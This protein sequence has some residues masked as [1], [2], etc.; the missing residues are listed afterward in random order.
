MG[1]KCLL[2]AGCFQHV[3]ENKADAGQSVG[4]DPQ[5][6]QPRGGHLGEGC[7]TQINEQHQKCD[8]DIAG[9][10]HQQVFY[11]LFLFFKKCN[12]DVARIS[13][14]QLLLQGRFAR[15]AAVPADHG[16]MGNRLRLSRRKSD[17]LFRIVGM[18][19][20]VIDDINFVV[21][22]FPCA[23]FIRHRHGVSLVS[24]SIERSV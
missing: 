20:A 15:H 18:H 9:I 10:S 13:Y 23:G 16:G 8:A 2:C 3:A 21:L 4:A 17:D 19:I 7:K 11:H 5:E 22:Q 12:T 6:V 1:I 24:V 14:Q